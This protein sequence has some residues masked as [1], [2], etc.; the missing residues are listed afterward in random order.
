MKQALKL[1]TLLLL[2]PLQTL[3]QQ[4]I[5]G[6]EGSLISSQANYTVASQFQPDTGLLFVERLDRNGI[7]VE[8]VNKFFPLPPTPIC[9]QVTYGGFLSSLA[10]DGVVP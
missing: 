4:G 5:G 2:A 10:A 7:I 6:S 8:M 3:Q 9:N 1:S